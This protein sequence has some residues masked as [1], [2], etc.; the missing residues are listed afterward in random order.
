M[1]AAPTKSRI[2]VLY[3]LVEQVESKLEEIPSIMFMVRFYEFLLL[4]YLILRNSIVN[5]EYNSTA[6]LN[7][8]FTVHSP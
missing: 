5:P 6:I 2:V 3:S 8:G 7:P 1:V 4:L